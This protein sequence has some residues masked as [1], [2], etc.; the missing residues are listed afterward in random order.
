MP[1]MPKPK[2]DNVIFVQSSL[3]MSIYLHP[4]SKKTRHPTRVHNLAKYE[5]ISKILSLLDSVQNLLQK[6]HYKSHHIL[7][8]L[9]HY[10]LKPS[11]FSYWQVLEQTHLKRNVK[12]GQCFQFPSLSSALH[13]ARFLSDF[14]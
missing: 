1:D 3:T 8:T 2:R 13:Q 14:S 11:C 5:S 12:F 9:L 10:P 4:V 6:D 7:K